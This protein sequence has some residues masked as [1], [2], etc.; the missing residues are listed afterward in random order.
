MRSHLDVV[1]RV[2]DEAHHGNFKCIHEFL[3]FS[4]RN[5]SFIHPHAHDADG[6]FFDFF[7]RIQLV[8]G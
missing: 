7:V 8:Y 6:E 5:G 2:T 3:E 4:C 1:L